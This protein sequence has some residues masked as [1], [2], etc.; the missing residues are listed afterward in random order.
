MATSTLLHWL[1]SESLFPIPITA[2]NFDRTQTPGNLMSITSYSPYA[3]IFAVSMGGAM[4]IAILLLG[5]LRRYP[6]ST[7]LAV[8]CSAS[9]AAACQPHGEGWPSIGGASVGCNR[10][11]P[12]DHGHDEVGHAT[13]SSKEV[14][15]L[16]A[17]RTYA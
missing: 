13:F 12:A 17:S 14:F 15:P 1:I 6:A 11:G 2:Y 16:I 4:L 3:I 8:C 10:S 5:I 7:P 9:I